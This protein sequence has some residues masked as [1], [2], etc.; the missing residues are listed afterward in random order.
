MDG[1]SGDAKRVC[2]LVAKTVSLS[3]SNVGCE[4]S[5]VD[6]ILVNS[7]CRTRI[8]NAAF[9]RS[10][11]MASLAIRETSY[12]NQKSGSESSEEVSCQMIDGCR[13]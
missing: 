7:A 10:S 11:M 13:I 12:E 4:A 6:V 3:R 1:S 2:G 9:R 5:S 8:A